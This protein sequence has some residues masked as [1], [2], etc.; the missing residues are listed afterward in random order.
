MSAAAGHS[1]V[2][3]TVE[4][5]LTGGAFARGETTVGYPTQPAASVL[6]EERTQFD[7]F[8]DAYRDELASS[9]DGL[10][11]SQAR[12][13][14]VPSATT[15]L[16]LVKHAT[17]V[18]AVWFREAVAGIPRTSLGLPAA[19]PDSF[20]LD[21]TDTIPGVLQEHARACEISRSMVAT[22]PLDTVV[23][24]H[25]SGPM[26]LRWIY[27]HCL[28]ELAQHCGHAD[29]LREQIL[30]GHLGADV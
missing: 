23:T 7:T 4:R 20:L 10:T 3:D 22:M 17:Y 13:A 28:R 21:E 6:A 12:A 14:L 29:I 30:S 26:T 1:Q 5:P 18:E 25:H 2:A 24:G 15:L 27:L 16:G 8:L 9:L 19:A 11:E